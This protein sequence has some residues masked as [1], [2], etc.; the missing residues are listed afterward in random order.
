MKI[1]SKEKCTACYACLNVCPINCISM[2]MD[3]IGVLYPKVDEERCV[4]CNLCI[5]SCPNNRILNFRYPNK[6]YASWIGD[7]KKRKICASGGLATAFSEYIIKYENG[8]VYGTRYDKDMQPI[9]TKCTTVD[10]LEYFKGSK[11]VQSLVRDCFHEIKEYLQQQRVVLYIATPCQIAGLYSYLKKDYSNLLTIDLICHGVSPTSY[12]N[13]E[14]NYLKMTK[15]ISSI[16]DIRFRGNDSKNYKLSLWDNKQLK[17]CKS[18]YH[19]YYFSGFLK[20][21]SLRENCY[22]CDYARPERLS[23]ITIGD[24]IGLGKDFPFEY[25]INNVSVVLI[26]SV[27]GS[28]LLENMRQNT[29]LLYAVEREYD[30]A[31]KYGPSLCAPFPKHPKRE[32]FVTLCREK[33][34]VYAIRRVLKYEIYRRKLLFVFTWIVRFIR[35]KLKTL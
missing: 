15:K 25:S 14:I 9:T 18:A 7:L 33:G 23:D 11:Y 31:I 3:S 30:E 1:C 21:I 8:I 16:T 12:F 6:C 17:Y 26:N 35:T 22:A 10:E 32:K 20:G 29:L 34:Y 4:N 24:F 13:N 2:Q 27:R 28:S 19:Q 5:K